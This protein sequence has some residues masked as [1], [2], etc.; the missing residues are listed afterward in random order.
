[1]KKI[2]LALALLM[3]FLLWGPNAYADDAQDTIIDLGCTKNERMTAGSSMVAYQI[4]V[5]NG[6]AS[7]D[8]ISLSYA[9]TG[10]NHGA[11]ADKWDID[12]VPT[13]LTL[14]PGKTSYT[15][16]QVK[17]SCG[18]EEGH[19]IEIT[20]TGVSQKDPTKTDSVITY[21]TRGSDESSGRSGFRSPN[22][23]PSFVLTIINNGRH[24]LVPTN[25]EH[26]EIIVSNTWGGIQ[27][28]YFTVPNLPSTAWSLKFSPEVVVLTGATSKVVDLSVFLNKDVGSGTYDINIIAVSN[29]AP[30]LI[31]SSTLMY[32]Q[33]PDVS[34]SNLTFS[35]SSD[36]GNGVPGLSV[37][38][39]NRGSATA[40]GLQVSITINGETLDTVSVERINAISSE[41]ILVP[42][43]PKKEQNQLEATVAY[44]EQSGN[45]EK[46]SDTLVIEE[47]TYTVGSI[48]NE[49]DWKRL[50]TILVLFVIIA[51]ISAVYIAI[52]TRK[53]E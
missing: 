14:D 20:V 32:E 50:A 39:E 25:F 53:T 23:A 19:E 11:K 38:I 21:T 22:P 2:A 42:W 34:I 4:S 41:D 26:H 29:E 31:Q 7:V 8:T 36:G 30:S 37:E 48:E 12:L 27:S 9:V 15:D 47:G 13:T 40:T 45:P 17:A 1:L 18:C 3:L 46:Y 51:A 5:T 33:H 52:R 24:S 28:I 49:S 16:L 35:P 10:L 44:I 6:G 43:R